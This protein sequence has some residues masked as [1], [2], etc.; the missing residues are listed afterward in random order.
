MWDALSRYRALILVGALLIAPPIL[1]WGQ[2]RAPNARGPVVGLVIEL[3]SWI[4][5]PLLAV[6]GVIS[7]GLTVY[8]GSVASGEE[9]IRLRRNQNELVAAKN[10]LREL[11]QE[12]DALR[13]LAQA[14]QRIDGPRPLGARIIGRTGAPLTRLARID[15]G[16]TDGIR[17]G[18]GVI[19]LAGVVGQILSVGRH[20]SDIL[21]MTDP[22]SALDVVVQRTRA[23][24]I[25]RGSGFDDAYRARVEDFDRLEDVQSGDTLVTSAL[26]AH[27]PPGILVGEIREVLSRADSV[28]RRAEV[29][30]AVDMAA[31][32]H[33]LVL[34]GRRP[35]RL[36]KLGDGAPDSGA[37]PDGTEERGAPLRASGRVLNV[38]VAEWATLEMPPTAS[39]P[40]VEVARE[41]KDETRPAPE[42]TP[43]D[44]DARDAAV[45][46]ALAAIDEEAAPVSESADAK[47]SS[48]T[49]SSAED[50]DSVTGTDGPAGSGGLPSS[51]PNSIAASGAE[52]SDAFPPYYEQEIPVV[53]PAA[54]DESQKPAAMQ[55]DAA[56]AGEKAVAAVSDENNAAGEPGPADENGP[57]AEAE[58]RASTGS[59]DG[60]VRG[61]SDS[62]DTAA[63][64][65][66]GS[67][68][69]ET[70]DVKS[71]D[72]SGAATGSGENV[73][74]EGAGN[75]GDTD[76]AE[77]EAPAE[78]TPPEESAP[79]T[80]DSVQ[81]AGQGA[82][83]EKGKAG[84]DENGAAPVEP[85]SANEDD[86]K[87]EPGAQGD[88]AH[89]MPE[90]GVRF[91]G[92]LRDDI[93][94][95]SVGMAG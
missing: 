55:E 7:D 15:R 14:A 34:I 59:G 87:A 27:F 44:N 53:A 57:S 93:T 35:E 13:H 20:T 43:E 10:R 88:S 24:G 46:Q 51:N 83:D 28:Y 19:T 25:I 32:E 62:T 61:E 65:E 1:L 3:A 79:P 90:V 40:N 4:E 85:E 63:P 67:G 60:T 52:A 73:P 47:S 64:K 89:L 42:P 37:P 22:L 16:K 21:L 76:S 12:N 6:S 33:V 48:L 81:P 94:L 72:G 41:E 92:L 36:P 50:A 58:S 26:T 17:R 49:A 18:D 54:K 91:A 69:N 8:L 86:A 2:T 31:L 29:V 80:T 68:E 70:P 5:R 84:T 9:L 56:A 71:S 75:A 45:E 30:P 74:V 23:R 95:P 77:K 39:T 11:E 82:K 38:P 66:Q 78:S